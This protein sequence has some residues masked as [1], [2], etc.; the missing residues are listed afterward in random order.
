MDCSP[1]DSSVHGILQASI[2]EWVAIHFS[3]G[4]PWPR[5]GT[6]VSFIAGRFFTIWAT[7]EALIIRQSLCIFMEVPLLAPLSPLSI[8]ICCHSF[9]W[10]I[11]FNISYRVVFWWWSITAFLFWRSLVFEIAVFSSLS[12]LQRHLSPVF[13]LDL[14]LKMYLLSCM[15]LFLH[16]MQLFPLSGGF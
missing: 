13:S 4:S 3:R 12:E 7:G 8:S 15:S 10:K 9:T 1:P 2:L 11:S 5:D 6:R 14:F 16:V